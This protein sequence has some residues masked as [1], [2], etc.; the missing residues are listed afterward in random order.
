M[1]HCIKLNLPTSFHKLSAACEAATIRTKIL[2]CLRQKL[3]AE[4]GV[5]K[6]TDKRFSGKRREAN[7]TDVNQPLQNQLIYHN[8]DYCIPKIGRVRKDM[9]NDTVNGG[10]FTGREEELPEAIGQWLSCRRSSTSVKG[11]QTQRVSNVS[12]KTDQYVPVKEY[13]DV[14]KTRSIITVPVKEYPDTK[15]ELK[16]K[17]AFQQPLQ[18]VLPSPQTCSYM[19]VADPP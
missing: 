18:A 11:I 4:S 14:S 19:D 6:Q 3:V 2:I 16:P 1:F 8:T 15:G 17:A 5:N 9:Y 12:I 13:P 10:M 7:A